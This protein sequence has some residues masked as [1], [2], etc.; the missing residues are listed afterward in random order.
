MKRSSFFERYNYDDKIDLK[1]D[2]PEKIDKCIGAIAFLYIEA[3]KFEASPDQVS[4]FN[5]TWPRLF[6]SDNN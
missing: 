5:V 4:N 3:V 2:D 6:E 1:I